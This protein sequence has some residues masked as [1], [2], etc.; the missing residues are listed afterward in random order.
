MHIPYIERLR[1]HKLHFHRVPRHTRFLIWVK[2]LLSLFMFIIMFLIKFQYFIFNYGLL[3]RRGM[4]AE[5]TTEIKKK[6]FSWNRKYLL[7]D[8][9][10]FLRVMLNSFLHSLQLKTC[11][12]DAHW[13]PSP[14]DEFASSCKSII[15]NFEIL[16][17]FPRSSNAVSC[18]LYCS[19]NW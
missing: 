1:L 18:S 9:L 13:P 8:W 17:C 6:C 14:F 11:L 3:L 10:T 12:S 5:T 4:C 16:N 2:F 19:F 7:I 15:C